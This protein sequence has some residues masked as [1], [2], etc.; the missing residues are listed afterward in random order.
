ML[1]FWF[2]VAVIL[3]Q[4]IQLQRLYMHGRSPG[5]AVA[6]LIVNHLLVEESYLPNLPL[7]LRKSSSQSVLVVSPPK[8]LQFPHL[9]RLEEFSPEWSLENESQ[10]HEKSKSGTVKGL[11]VDDS[12]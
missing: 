9:I 5:G 7:M 3:L 4:S 1:V 12:M 8:V 2:L 10:Y 11:T 6:N